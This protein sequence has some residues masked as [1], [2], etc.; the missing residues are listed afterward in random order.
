MKVATV[1]A[2]AAAAALAG[3]SSIPTAGPTTAQVLDQA[4]KQDKRRF[5]VVEIDP[6]VVSTLSGQSSSSL[7]AQF[8]RYGRPRTPT[9]GIGDTVL[10]SI[11]EAGSGGVFGAAATE[12]PSVVVLPATGGG[13]HSITIP[14]Q[15]VGPDGGISVPYAGRV[16]VAGRTPL[17]VQQSIEHSLADRAIE[18]QVIVTVTK[19]VSDAVT[20]SGELVAGAR[21]PLSVGGDRLLDVIASAGGAKSPLYE[22]FVRLS[23]DGVTVTIPMDTLVSHPEE[24]IYAWPGDV[25]TLVRA[26]R[27]FLVFGA[28]VTNLQVPFDASDLNLAQAVAKAGGLQ[29][30]RADPE[31]VFLF[32]FEPPSVVKALGA[33]ELTT[34]PDGSSP[35]LYHLNLR[36]VTGYFL[37][38]RFPVEDNDIIYVAN[39]PITQLQKFF[40]LLG[41]ISGP[42]LGGVVLTHGTK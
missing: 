29:D 31:G 21:V 16:P 23:R 20:V 7:R 39:A 17:Q 14:D 2:C 13:A 9:I 8:E 22:T 32:R 42:V 19:N 10:V 40:T 3:C 6:R 11:W 1:F 35:I 34:A 37:A 18:P 15:V 4:V 27:T 38:R 33:P 25:I 24:N 28:T 41:T 12:N 5:D 26:P 30:A 36:D